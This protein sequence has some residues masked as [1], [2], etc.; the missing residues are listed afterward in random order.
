VTFS[1]AAGEKVALVGPNGTGKTSMLRQIRRADH[2]AITF[3]PEAKPAFFSQLHE[4][5]FRGEST[6]YETFFD[7]GFET[8]EDIEAYLEDYCFDP[9][10]LH[11]KVGNLSGGE[12]NL[13][14]LALLAVGESNLLLLDEPS[15]HL[16]TFAQMALEDAIADAGFDRNGDGQVLIRL[17]NYPV[18]L[19]DDS[20]NA[21][22]KN[23]QIVAALDAD[24]IGHTSGLFLLEDPETFQAVTDERLANTFLPFRDGL[25]LCIPNNAEEAYQQLFEQIQES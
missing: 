7:V 15:S 21:G 17:H 16:D 20:E 2:P 25:Y 23:H 1:L 11:R 4:E 6:I 5:V 19:A 3:S 13:L 12:K 14:Q 9:L 8:R 22:V 18:D 10:S 24:L